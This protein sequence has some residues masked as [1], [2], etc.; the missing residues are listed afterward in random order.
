MKLQLGAINT[1]WTPN[2][3]FPIVNT[4]ETLAADIIWRLNTKK[5][6]VLTLSEVSSREL[7][8]RID[9]A[10]IDYE[11]V[12]KKFGPRVKDNI[13][14]VWDC[15]TYENEQNDRATVA[16]YG[17]YMGVPLTHLRLHEK[18]LHVSVHMPRKNGKGRAFQLL[19]KYLDESAEKYDQVFVHGD[20]NEK[21]EGL[22]EKLP[23]LEFAFRDQQTTRAG[24]RLDNVGAWEGVDFM[25]QDVVKEA[26]YSHHVIYATAVVENDAA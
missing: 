14:L 22:R 11:T 24:N 10:D 23:N 4:D 19:L 15:A 17:K 26:P 16:E 8:T 12:F 18:H 2:Q 13:A 21:P 9:R 5:P 6:A 1:D 20:F 7:V 3:R 25:N